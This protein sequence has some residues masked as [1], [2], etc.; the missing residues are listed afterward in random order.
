ML[1]VAQRLHAGCGGPAWGL[2]AHLLGALWALAGAGVVS[3]GDWLGGSGD[4]GASLW[5]AEL[6]GLLELMQS[7]EAFA[8]SGPRPAH[9]LVGMQ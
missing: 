9:C 2:E 5:D 8:M 4:S 1:A 6:L 7:W 3:S